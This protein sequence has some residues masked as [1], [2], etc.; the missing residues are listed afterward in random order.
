[1][2][3]TVAGKGSLSSGSVEFDGVPAVD[4]KWDV[5]TKKLALDRRGRPY[6]P[7][8]DK[9]Y[10]IQED[11]LMQ[12]VAGGHPRRYFG[13]G[14]PPTQANFGTPYGIAVA[15]DGVVYVAEFNN[16][17]VRRIG[18]PLPG[19]FDTPVQGQLRIPSAIGNEIFVFTADGR[20]L[21]TESAFTGTTKYTFSYDAT[22]GALVSVTDWHGNITTIIRNGT[23]V[24]ITRN[25]SIGGPSYPDGPSQ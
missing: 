2:L 21:L 3:V 25:P 18:P 22:T 16:E 17:R 1:M 6:F 13:D 7:L 23:T 20:H 12:L 19:H 8:G 24:A 5:Q 14:Y 9:I 11:G 4:T 15:P 10:R